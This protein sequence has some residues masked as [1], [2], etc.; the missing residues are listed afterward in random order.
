MLRNLR[1]NALISAITISSAS[2]Y[3]MFG[4]DQGVLGGLIAQPSFLNAIGNPSSSYLGTIVALYNI[5]CLAGCMVAAVYG[6]KFGRRKM[7]TY[8]CI[9]MVI[10]GTIQASIYGALQ[11]IAGR[12]IS[13]VGNG[14]SPFSVLPLGG[15]SQANSWDSGMNTATIPVY[16]SEVARNHRRGR[17]VA[18]QLSVVIV[19]APVAETSMRLLLTASSS[20]PSSPAGSTMEPSRT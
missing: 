11:L 2:C 1:G 14:Q 8:G 6:N 17:M 16:I 15:R 13:G 19:N 10:G 12:L 5:G 4:Y 9:I 20:V 7:I 18:V 3:L